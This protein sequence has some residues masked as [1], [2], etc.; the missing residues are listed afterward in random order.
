MWISSRD[1]VIARDVIDSCIVSWSVGDWGRCSTTC[2]PGVRSRSVECKQRVSASLELSVSASQCSLERRP[3]SEE[4]CNED[5]ACAKWQLGAWGKVAS[6]L[7]YN[8]IQL[9]C[10]R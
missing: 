9:V 4:A 2:D 5:R 1:L 6:A 8:H 10:R 3:H 7:K